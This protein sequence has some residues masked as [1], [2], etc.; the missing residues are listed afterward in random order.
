[1]P[2]LKLAQMFNVNCCKSYVKMLQVAHAVCKFLDMRLAG[3]TTNH[4]KHEVIDL[5]ALLA[6]HNLPG[7]SKPGDERAKLRKNTHVDVHK[8]MASP[9]SGTSVAH[10]HNCKNNHVTVPLYITCT[11]M[12]ILCQRESGPDRFEADSHLQCTQACNTM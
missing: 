7:I 4:G 12:S 6:F 2:C 10:H 11:I 5:G 8:I 3:M 9:A 1:M